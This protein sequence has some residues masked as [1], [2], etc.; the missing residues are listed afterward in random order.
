MAPNISKLKDAVERLRGDVSELEGH[1]GN[2]DSESTA[3][4]RTLR[5]VAKRIVLSSQYLEAL[6][7]ENT[8][9]P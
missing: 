8:Y 9:S 4:G 1:F 7:R 2:W 6:V 3:G 5:S